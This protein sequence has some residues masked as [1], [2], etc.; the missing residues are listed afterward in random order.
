LEKLTAE[1]KKK[2]ISIQLSQ[3]AESIKR[4]YIVLNQWLQVDTSYIISDQQ[5]K[6]VQLKT[7]DYEL[8]PTIGYYNDALKLSQHLQKLEKQ[9]LLPDI[10]ASLF[11]GLNNGIGKQFYTGVQLGVAIPLWRG[12]QNSKIAAA[13]IGENIL[14]TESDN[15]KLQLQSKYEALLSDIRQYDEGLN[16][17]ESTGNKL[18]KETLFYANEAYK[19]GE[20][21]FL[22]YIQLLENAKTIESNYLKSLFQYN[23]T[24]LEVNFLIN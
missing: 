19:N 17:Y 1:T 8:H 13:R 15:Y 6:R 3:I 22:Q 9:K 12:S 24:A 18:S 23:M 4:N 21:N 7:F 10:N 16:Y 5:L 11:Q 2:E 20:I 14:M